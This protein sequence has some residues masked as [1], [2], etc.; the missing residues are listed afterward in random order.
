MKK[1]L[2]ALTI[3]LL[4]G[5]GVGYTMYSN[6]NSTSVDMDRYGSFKVADGKTSD[7]EIYVDSYTKFQILLETMNEYYLSMRLS[8]SQVEQ[9]NYASKYVEK[10]IELQEEIYAY[11]EKVA[12]PTEFEDLHES[13]IKEIAYTD[14][15]S[16]EFG[17][18][19]EKENF[20]KVE[21]LIALQKSAHEEGLASTNMVEYRK[22]ESK[23][24]LND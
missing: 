11:N 24:H 19:I 7:L 8:S 20:D 17:D 2:V 10:Y 14:L 1:I 12:I 3:L 4:V 13:L 22:S 16:E 15:I 5:G 21:E 23:Y 6:S 9:F 18:A